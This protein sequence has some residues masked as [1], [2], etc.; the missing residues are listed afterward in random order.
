[1]VTSIAK[2]NF[3]SHQYLVTDILNARITKRFEK[4]YRIINLRRY[5]PQSA[6]ETRKCAGTPNHYTTVYQIKQSQNGQ[7]FIGDT[8]KDF[9]ILQNETKMQQVFGP[10]VDVSLPKSYDSADAPKSKYYYLQHFSKRI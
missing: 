6:N 1:M 9:A 3:C 4:T 7:I 8:P 10:K 2:R 5:P